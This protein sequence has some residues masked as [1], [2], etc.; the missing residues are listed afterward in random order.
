MKCLYTCYVKVWSENELNL[1]YDLRQ[2]LMDYF[3]HIEEEKEYKVFNIMDGVAIEIL[4]LLQSSF[5]R[6]QSSDEFIKIIS[7][8]VKGKNV[9]SDSEK[10]TNTDA[11]MKESINS[12]IADKIPILINPFTT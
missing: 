3:E 4:R 5:R 10:N 2:S 6:F 11:V 8:K 1:S 12:K 7:H 9:K